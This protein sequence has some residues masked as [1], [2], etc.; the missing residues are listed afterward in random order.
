MS[1]NNDQ[2]TQIYM[3]LE[4]IKVLPASA[5][6]SRK[7]SKNAKICRSHIEDLEEARKQQIQQLSPEYHE[8]EKIRN[9]L[10]TDYAKKD[11]DGN[12]IK[13]VD[14]GRE[15]FD[16]TDEPLARQAFTT[17]MQEHTEKYKKAFKEKEAVD[18]EFAV[19][20]KE[21]LDLDSIGFEKIK[22]EDWPKEGITR[23]QMDIL[24]PL[25]E[26]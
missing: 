24:D 6:G 20:L 12:I 10:C 22:L 5:I 7:Q 11:P 14:K 25:V 19:L 4:Q 15:I 9:E 13:R 23:E 21:E 2:M 17:K 26:D 3:V 18:K 1:F 8:A 16:I